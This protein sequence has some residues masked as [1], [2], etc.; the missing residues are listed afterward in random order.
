MDDGAAAGPDEKE[1]WREEDVIHCLHRNVLGEII[2][3]IFEL[4]SHSLHQIEHECPREV[5]FVS[6]GRG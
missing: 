3:C 5:S 2:D 6:S 1:A 4:N